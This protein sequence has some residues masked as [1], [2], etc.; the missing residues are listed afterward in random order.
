MKITIYDI[1]VYVVF[2]GA[3]SLSTIER[4]NILPFSLILWV[5]YTYLALIVKVLIEKNKP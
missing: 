4:Q 1:L 2:I 5:F 3:L